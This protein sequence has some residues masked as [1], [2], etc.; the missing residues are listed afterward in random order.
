MRKH[1]IARV[2]AML[3][4]CTV[5]LSGCGCKHVWAEATCEVPKTCIE[6]GETEGEALGHVSGETQTVTDGYALKVYTNIICNR[7][8]AVISTEESALSALKGETC[9]VCSTA[10]Y[11]RRVQDMIAQ[12]PGCTLNVELTEKDGDV[13][14]L[15]TDAA[16]DPVGA[17]VFYDEMGS[18]IEYGKKDEQSCFA[19]MIVYVPGMETAKGDLADI[20]AAMFLAAD[21]A[22]DIEY[23]QNRAAEL[24]IDPL[25]VVDMDYLLDIDGSQGYYGVVCPEWE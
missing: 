22:M 15:I 9:M 19:Y 10:E 11:T 4:V 16:G 3:M 5:V 13:L 6:C 20:S 23:A 21:P 8:D 24:T 1:R 12:I 17:I 25:F 14:G 7:C 2:L 18:A